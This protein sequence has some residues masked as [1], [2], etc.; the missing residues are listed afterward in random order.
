MSPICLRVGRP[1]KASTF[2]ATMMNSIFLL[3]PSNVVSRDV[4]PRT[5]SCAPPYAVRSVL[6]GSG[7]GAHIVPCMLGGGGCCM[8]CRCRLWLSILGH[9]CPV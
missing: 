4:F 7:G 9:E 2:S 1:I 3:T 8:W 5:V 6:V